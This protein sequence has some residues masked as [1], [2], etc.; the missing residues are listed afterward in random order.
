MISIQQIRDSQNKVVVFGNHQP[1]IQSILDF[2]YLSGKKEGSVIGIVTGHRGFAK[3]FFGRR[4][5]LIPTLVSMRGSD[6]MGSQNFWFLNLLSG[7]RTLPS[8]LE[9]LTLKEVPNPA[10]GGEGQT[11]P[12][13]VGGSLFAENVPELHS[14]EIIHQSSTIPHQPL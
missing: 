12:V 1:I 10:F 7:R 4:E 3:F 5:I 9:G 8:V 14:L 2:D 13:F 11:L 6:P